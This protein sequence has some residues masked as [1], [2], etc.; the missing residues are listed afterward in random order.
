[1][2]AHAFGA[3]LETVYAVTH[4]GNVASQRLC[5]RLGMTHLGRTDRYYRMTCELFRV[6]GERAGASGTISA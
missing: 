6:S 5:R 1:M 4:P 2:L 3:G